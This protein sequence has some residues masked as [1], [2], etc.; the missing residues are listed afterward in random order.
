MDKGF[1]YLAQEASLH[2]G[3]YIDATY[4]KYIVYIQDIPPTTRLY[5]NKV[6]LLKLHIVRGKE[7]SFNLFCAVNLMLISPAV[8]LCAL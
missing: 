3:F 6:G 5:F 7:K 1:L 4:L 2:C 8:C